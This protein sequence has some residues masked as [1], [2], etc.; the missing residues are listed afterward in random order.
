VFYPEAPGGS[1]NGYGPLDL[2]IP[3]ARL[4]NNLVNSAAITAIKN[5]N[6]LT[7]IESNDPDDAGQKYDQFL[8]EAL[9][10]EYQRP[11]FVSA[12]GTGTQMKSQVIGE[13]NGTPTMEYWWNFILNQATIRT[14][15]NYS[16]LTDLAGTAAQDEMK[17][18]M[19]QSANKIVLN[20]NRDVDQEMAMDDLYLLKNG[21]SCFHDKKV[22][23]ERSLE[24]VGGTWNESPTQGQP[25]MPGKPPPKNIRIGKFI[26]SIDAPQYN[27]TPMVDGIF[28]NVNMQEVR[29]M[30]EAVALF[31]GTKAGA[32]AGKM[33]A[34]EVLPK[35]RI[36]EEDFMA[37]Q[38]PP[39]PATGEEPVQP[40]PTNLQSL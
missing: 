33:Y 6:P 2:L 23:L 29:A 16:S 5:A 26:K 3:L 30:K 39:S 7:I 35:A 32:K 4:E 8:S 14:R 11:F 20:S 15:L 10:S 28:D 19:E 13:G 12:S 27:V 40:R 24:S 18:Q 34:D 1:Y 36:T 21:D 31:A 22:Y 17:I 25:Q 37:P 38:L 9:T